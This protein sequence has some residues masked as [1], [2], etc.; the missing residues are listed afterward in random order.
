VVLAHRKY[1]ASLPFAR[2][3][4]VAH[5]NYFVAPRRCVRFTVVGEAAGVVADVP[6]RG[7]VT[8]SGRRYEVAAVGAFKFPHQ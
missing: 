3:F 2:A 1:Y 7:V 4:P 8:I 5:Y 6:A